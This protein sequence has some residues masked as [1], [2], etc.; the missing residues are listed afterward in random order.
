MVMKKENTVKQRWIFAAAAA[1][2]VLRLLLCRAVYIQFSAGSGYDDLMQ[3]AKAMEIAGGNWLGKYGSMTLVKGVGFP[4]LTAVFHWLK[5]PYVLGWNL[6]YVVACVLFVWAL[7]PLVKNRLLLLLCY[8]LL[9]YNPAAFDSGINRYYRDIG[10]YAV[11]FCAVALLL[12]VL[13]RK[14]LWFVFV[15]GAVTA[16]AALMREDSQWLYIYALGCLIAAA[17]LQL[18]A[19]K[20]AVVGFAGCAVLLVMG[21]VVV[22]LPISLLNHHYYGTFALDEYNSG[23]YAEAYGAL[24]RLDGGLRDSHITIPRAERM[25]LYEAS[26]AFARMYKYLDAPDAFFQGWV[27]EQGEYRTGYFSFVLRTAAERDGIFADAKTADAYFT[28]LAK[29]VNDY[30]DLLPEAGARRKGIAARFY[31]EDLPDI[32]GAWLRG[33]SGAARFSGVNVLPIPTWEDDAYLAVYEDFTGAECAAKRDYPDGTSWENYHPAGFRLWMQRG[34]RVLLLG[35]Q[36]AMPLLALLA[37]LAWIWMTACTVAG[38]ELPCVWVADCSLA[39]LFLLRVFM[40]GYVDA[41]TFSTIYT[42]AYQ[43][44]SYPLL[45]GFTALSL[46]WA[47]ERLWKGFARKNAAAND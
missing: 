11:A 44:A 28:Q 32:I 3:I 2:T 12:A 21:A 15:G 13:T 27:A 37:V 20:K 4:L 19:W 39:C 38:K 23:S 33:I 29:E 47:G 34:T 30:C 24:S 1:A 25:K 35:Y 36:R 22:F 45:L 14:S 9:L 5:I 41:T 43:A 26:P 42:P 6:I 17:V 46:C 16:L 40:L 31:P 18:P 7:M 8:L 10:Y